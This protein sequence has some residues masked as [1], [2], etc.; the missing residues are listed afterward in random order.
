[1]DGSSPAVPKEQSS[2]Q[3]SIRTAIAACGLVALLFVP[4]CLIVVLQRSE[5]SRLLRA[6][7][8]IPAALSGVDPGDALLADI[9]GRRAAILFFSVDCPHCQWQIPIFNEAMRRFG[10]EVEFVAVAL[11][12]RQK[13]EM[14][15]QANDVRVK[16][17]IDQK[18]GVGRIFGISELPVLF[19]VDQDQRVDWVGAGEQPRSEVFR[20]LSTLVDNKRSAA[21]PVN[22][23]TRK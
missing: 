11:N 16:V 18:G 15:I 9:S 3:P 7:E 1:M 21:S 2:Q 8:S 10:A 14:F 4:V 20:R 19:L 6:G 12:N 5:G 22:E 17:L 13:T 23:K